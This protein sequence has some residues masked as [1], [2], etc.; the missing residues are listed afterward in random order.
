MSFQAGWS[1]LATF[2]DVRERRC[3]I[4]C[5]TSRTGE[6]VSTSW[7][8]FLAE[9]LLKL[10]QQ[11]SPTAWAFERLRRTGGG[12]RIGVIAAELGWS[13]K[14][15]A[16]KFHDEIGLAPKMVARMAR[17]NFALLRARRHGGGG[18]AA[19]ADECGYADQAH[20]VRDFKAFAGETPTAW[21]ARLDQ[22]ASQCRIC[23]ANRL[24]R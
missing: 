18:W 6:D 16:A 1:R 2:W 4:G 13:R 22:G 7:S 14:H 5:A 24:P 15:L 23:V 17:F 12:D 20:L 9:R 11:L 10:D 21:Q 8:F 3:A 19:L